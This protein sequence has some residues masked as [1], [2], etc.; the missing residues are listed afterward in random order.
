LQSLV[1]LYHDTFPT[2]EGFTAWPNV[3]PEPTL[4]DIEGRIE[5]GFLLCGD[6]DEVTEQ[7]RKYQAVG[8]DQVAF[9]LPVGLPQELA[10]ETLRLF[11]QEVIPRFDEDPVHRSTRMRMGERVLQP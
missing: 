11:G 2:P 9:G 8:C 4:D 7:V 1:F 3:M 5:A 6:P 10:L